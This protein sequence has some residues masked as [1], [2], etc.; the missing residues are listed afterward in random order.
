MNGIQ[1]NLSK[2]LELRKLRHT[3]KREL[4]TIHTVQNYQN[5]SYL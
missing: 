2:V 1:K 4:L 5:V 3:D